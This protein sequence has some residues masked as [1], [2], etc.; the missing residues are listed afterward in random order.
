MRRKVGTRT[1]IT[2]LLAAGCFVPLA[3]SPAVAGGGCYQPISEGRG[4]T[5]VMSEQCF[6]P[7]ILRVDRGTKVTW[8]NQDGVAHNVT[9]HAFS[10]GSDGDLAPGQRFSAMFR[11]PGV[12]AYACW[13]HPGMTGVVVVGD[14]GVPVTSSDG[15]P[16]DDTPDAAA[17]PP[18]AAAPA[19]AA[20]SRTVSAGAW[21]AVSAVGFGLA[22]GLGLAVIV[23]RRRIPHSAADR[24][25]TA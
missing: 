18:A 22:F 25:P 13:I 10:W 7:A 19:T 6:G 4:S 2:L 1:L 8:I 24:E 23:L 14:A 3:A 12:Y 17:K 16:T 21:P 20:V 11:K 9:G 15:A 5:V